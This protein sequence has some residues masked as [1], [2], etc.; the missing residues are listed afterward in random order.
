ME[1]ARTSE[2][3]ETQT[4]LKVESRMNATS[5]RKYTQLLFRLSLTNV[6]GLHQHSG[7]TK[8]SAVSSL[9]ARAKLPLEFEC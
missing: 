6:T 1:G 5:P 4:L 9:T 7:S 8:F 2:V 3:V